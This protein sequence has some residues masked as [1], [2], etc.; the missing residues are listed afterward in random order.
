MQI[1]Y[2]AADLRRWAM[3]CYDHATDPQTSGD[4]R[5]RLLRMRASLLE[6]ADQE[7]WLNGRAKAASGQGRSADHGGFK[8]RHKVMD[9][10]L[11][12]RQ[13]PHSN[14]SR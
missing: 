14:H 1:Q 10:E 13:W 4:E 3:Q 11:V 12:K 2:S 9:P 8:Q 5:D 7:D 6:L